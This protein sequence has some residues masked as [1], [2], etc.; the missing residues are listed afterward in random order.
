MFRKILITSLSLLALIWT[1]GLAWAH[2]QLRTAVPGAGSSV[3]APSEIKLT[4]S[5]GVE[6]KFSQVTL[7][8]EAGDAVALGK[9]EVD[10]G[11]NKILIVKVPSAL[12]AGTYKVTWHVVSVDT[13][14][15][16]GSFSFTVA[17]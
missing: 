5:E 7:A 4:Y 17:P 1:A 15:T 14:K 11:N 13:H 6:P 9:P 2:A 8:T 12:K 10:P 3:S 16:Q